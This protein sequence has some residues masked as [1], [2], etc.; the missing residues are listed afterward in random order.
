MVHGRFTIIGTTPDGDS[1]RFIPDDPAPLAVVHR[2]HR[3][4]STADGGVQVRFEAVDA[5]EA[6]YGNLAQ[7][8]GAE[9][10]DTLL[11][12]LGFT[13]VAYDPAVPTIVQAAEPETVRGTLLTKSADANGRLV[14]YVIAGDWT[15]PP[16][17]GH[18]VYIGGGLLGRTVNLALLQSGAAYYTVYTSTPHEHR[19]RLRAVAAAARAGGLGVWGR[20]TTAEWRLDGYASLGP[21]GQL[22]LPKLFRRC[23]DYLRAV[24]AGE[25]SSFDAW[26]AG[27]RSIGTRYT[28]DDRVVLAGVEQRLSDLVAQ[29]E[30]RVRFAADPLDVVF[31]EK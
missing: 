7:P 24:E 6:H 10:R 25:T 11:R 30:D 13:R 23:C 27:S 18:W 19:P 29:R 15:A 14:G 22:I 20:D 1:A 2:A 16:A 31:I 28:L 12:L 8:L 9:G 26:L 17:D 3:L 4:R 5:P 21:A